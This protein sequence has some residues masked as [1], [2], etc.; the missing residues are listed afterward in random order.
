MGIESRL[1]L[2]KKDEFCEKNKQKDMQF[3]SCVSVLLYCG[4]CF[5]N[6]F[7]LKVGMQHSHLI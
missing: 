5:S 2:R 6:K 7:K 1:E 3:N 4:S